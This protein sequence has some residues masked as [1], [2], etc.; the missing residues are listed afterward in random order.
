[1]SADKEFQKYRHR[2]VVLRLTSIIQLPTSTPRWKNSDLK[3]I[4]I[5]FNFYMLI[6]LL[7]Q[8]RRPISIWSK[9]KTSIITLLKKCIAQQPHTIGTKTCKQVTL[10]FMRTRKTTNLYYIVMWLA[11]YLR[12]NASQTKIDFFS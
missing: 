10:L 11:L 2:V 12:E 8:D 1:M 5:Y 3:H 7:P 9:Q 6:V 4:L